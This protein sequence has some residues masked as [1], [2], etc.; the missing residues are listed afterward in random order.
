MPYEHKVCF[1]GQCVGRQTVLVPAEPGATHAIDGV[2]LGKVSYR[3][4][5]TLRWL[6][7]RPPWLGLPSLL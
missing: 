4:F 3:Y 6:S 1:T 2:S 5:N 7:T